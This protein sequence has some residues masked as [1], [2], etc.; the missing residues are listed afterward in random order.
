MDKINFPYRSSTHLPLLHVISESGSW[1][2][3][4]LDVDYDQRIGSSHAH[5]AILAGDIEFVGGNHVSP[6]GRRTRG[7]RWIYLGQTVNVVPGRALAV[8]ADSGIN[9]IADLREKVVGTRGA[10]P[11]LN[12][13]LQLKQHGLDVDR[14]E[15]KIVSQLEGI[16]SRLESGSGPPMDT[17]NINAEDVSVPLWQ[18]VRDGKVDATFV[19]TAATFIAKQ[20]PTL[21]VIDL[22]AFPMIYFTTLSTSLS[23]TEKHRGIVE[24]FLKGVI[25]GIH[26]FKTRPERSAQIIKERYDNMGRLSDEVARALQASMASVL[27]PNL[28][29]SPE[30]IANVYQEGVRQDADA[31][32]VNPMSLWDTHFI[33]EIDDSGFVELLYQ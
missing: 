22:P 24:R 4:G 14:D 3:Y 20:Q 16:V 25:E 1:A 11:Q 12:D 19:D 8:R 26:F 15:V 2:K 31:R 9:S 32:K 6:Y 13:W 21:K 27:E 33:R 23:F 17:A 5:E 30:A 10:H 29:P 7:D 28:Y 18:W